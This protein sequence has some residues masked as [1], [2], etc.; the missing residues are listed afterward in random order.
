MNKKDRKKFE[1]LFGASPELMTE[2][3]IISPFFGTKLFKEQLRDSRN[4]S[5]LVFRGITGKFNGRKITFIN[6]GVGQSL[7]SDCVL[8]QDEKVTKKIIFLGAVGGVK[9]LRFAEQIFIDKAF[10]DADYFEKFGFDIGSGPMKHFAPDKQFASSALRFAEEKRYRLKKA[11]VI[12]LH[13]LWDQ[14]KR[15]IGKI[16][17]LNINSVDL[18]CALFYATANHKKIRSLALCYVSDLIPSRPYWSD[19]PPQD[20]VK[21]SRSIAGLVSLALGMSSLSGL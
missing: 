13:T 12:S 5:G 10:F 2:T 4:F 16:Y 20:R 18:E 9:D 8:A 6:T 1:K 17:D 21:I 19:F 15:L 7:V 11:S 3:L 14:N